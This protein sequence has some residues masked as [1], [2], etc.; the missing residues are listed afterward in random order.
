MSR[1]LLIAL[2]ASII[3]VALLS[4]C[5]SFYPVVGDYTLE[6]NQVLVTILPDS[7]LGFRI[8]GMA[9]WDDSSDVRK[10]TIQ[11]KEY[12]FYLGHEMRHCF[13]GHWHTDVN[14]GDWD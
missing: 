8:W 13:E 14:N 4:G 3:S 7:D 5:K 1:T 12:P 9:S 2:T 10:C 6:T 11:L